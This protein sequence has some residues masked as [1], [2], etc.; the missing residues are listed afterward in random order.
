M[1]PKL[2]KT[3]VAQIHRR[4][5]EFA[6]S[7]PRVRL[8]KAPQS[9]SASSEPNYLLTFHSK[10]NAGSAADQKSLPR[11]MRVV[12]NQKGNIVKITTSH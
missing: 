8:Q 5:P 10:A 1:D 12:V 2:L 6:N 3:I 11:W 4:F 7:Q 9:K